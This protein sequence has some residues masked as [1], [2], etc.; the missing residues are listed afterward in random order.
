MF[1]RLRRTLK[2]TR[3]NLQTRAILETPPLTWR[4][5]P[6]TVV[7]MVAGYDVQ[8]Y[9]AVMKAFYTRLGGGRIVALVASDVSE[10][11]RA[12]IRR[13]LGPVEFV[14]VESL[15]TG[16]CQRGGTWERLLYCV[17]RSASEYVI[18]IDCDVF[19]R[20]EIPDVVDCVKQNRPF[21]LSDRDSIPK[22][23]LHQ[24]SSQDH[25]NSDNIVFEFER[26]AS[27]F[28]NADKLL[29]VR[30]S[31]GFAGFARG[32]VDRSFIEE[33][34]MNGEAVLGPRWRE[35]GT[36]QIASNFAIANM[37]DSLPLQP[38]RYMNYEGQP[39]IPAQA[40]VVHFL[41]TWRFDHGFLAT[42]VNDEVRRQHSL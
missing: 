10:H 34:H 26:R 31:S 23:P 20:G 19:V 6:A 15:P 8:L 18:Q 37:P 40:S 32:A 22:L 24:W 33:F 36:E 41:G 14:D 16:R 28:P 30:G 11:N 27:Q 39:D 21:L 5:G 12:M 35:W 29:Y 3:F 4:D 38:P 25:R 1:Y 13:H 7:S 17:D 2:Y 42:M 9:I